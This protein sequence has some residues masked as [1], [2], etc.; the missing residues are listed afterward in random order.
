M[1]EILIV[2]KRM[3]QRD[4]PLD[5]QGSVSTATLAASLPHHH[6]L[7]SSIQPSAFSGQFDLSCTL[8]C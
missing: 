6:E 7:G 2:I 3:S 4:L 8:S 1:E 5:L